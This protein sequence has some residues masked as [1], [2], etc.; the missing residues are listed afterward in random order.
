MPLA[1]LPLPWGYEISPVN[2]TL[3]VWAACS[4]W[5]L[6]TL[7][8]NPETRASIL[9]EGRTSSIIIAIL[10]MVVLSPIVVAIEIYM[11]AV[12]ILRRPDDDD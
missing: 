12:F 4:I 2:L 3:L 11:S 1:N 9:R 10:S 7:F 6:T 5:V 8:V